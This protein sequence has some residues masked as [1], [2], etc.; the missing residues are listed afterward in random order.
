MVSTQKTVLI[1]G[2]SEGGLGDA[3]AQEFHKKG[4]RVFA[5]ARNLAKVKHLEAQ[6]IETLSL[7]VLDAASLEKAVATVKDLTGGTLD[8]LVNNAG[9]GYQAPLMDVDIDD[10]KKTFDIN[11][12]GLL[13]ASQAFVPLLAKSRGRIINIG[14]V[15]SVL[16]VPWAGVY[17]AS[18]GA[19]HMLSDT[20]AVELAPFGI[21]VIHVFAGTVQSKFYENALGYHLPADSIY[22]PVRKEVEAALNAEVAQAGQASCKFPYQ[23][24]RSACSS[25][26]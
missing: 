12:W 22:E 15:A 17:N 25:V 13:R 23:N 26:Y 24:K 2:C 10:A 21:D 19:V 16:G 18:K 14:S 20:M 1:T 7:D 5:T 6:G 11:V 9:G 8:I 3:L 4:L